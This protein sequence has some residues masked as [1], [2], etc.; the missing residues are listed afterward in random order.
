MTLLDFLISISENV[1]RKTENYFKP[2]H[3]GP[4]NDAETDIGIKS[5]WLYFF[6]RMYQLTNKTNCLNM[7]ENLSNYLISNKARPL[8]Y[9]FHHRLNNSKDKCNG[10]IGQAWT[11]EALAFAFSV[12]GDKKYIEIAEE[13]F[14]QHE[15]NEDLG[16]WNRLEIDGKVLSIDYTFNHQLW[17]AACASLF[18]TPRRDKIHERIFRFM[19]CLD[20]NLTVLD[21]GLIYHP[22]ERSL[23][24]MGSGWSRRSGLNKL[25]KNSLSFLRIIDEKKKKLHQI[26][27]K[28][29]INKS[30]GYHQFNMYAFAILKENLPDHP[31]WKSPE[32][33][34]SV[35][36]LLSDEYKNEVSENK[37]G[38]P[39]NP[40]GF[41]IPYAL[42]VFADISSDELIKISSLWVNEQFK[43]CYNTETKMMDKNTEDPLTHTARI[44]ELSRLPISILKKIELNVEFVGDFS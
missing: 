18:D 17:F 21:N 35:N 9:S 3:N 37:Y 16:L 28:K 15:F 11:F 13:V 5:H 33:N 27:K 2:G 23:N 6:S 41:E 40:P 30:I 34:K 36:F 19:D 29:M 42:K 44:Y 10:L 26:N 43:R 25:V 24:Q 1:I 4:Y 8:G 32:F 14:F 38:F 39:Y 22:I 20:E 7:V 12:L 31:F